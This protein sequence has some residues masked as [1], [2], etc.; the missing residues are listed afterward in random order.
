VATLD[1]KP[2]GARVPGPVTARVRQRYWELHAD[3]RY[4]LAVDYPE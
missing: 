2:V 1:G 3:P 4:T